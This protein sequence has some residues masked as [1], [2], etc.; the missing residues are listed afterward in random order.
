[1]TAS[2][3]CIKNSQL[4][5]MARKIKFEKEIKKHKHTK[6]KYGYEVIQI[7]DKIGDELHIDIWIEWG[8]LLGYVR[9]GGLI[10]HDYDIDFATNRMS[11]GQYRNFFK[12]LKS[13]GFK[14]TRQFRFKEDII[15][16]TYEYK[17]SLVDIDY[18]D[19]DENGIRYFEYDIG[20]NT[21]IEK[22]SG[23]YHYRCMDVMIY[24][25]IPFT[26]KRG[27]FSNGTSC[28]IPD[29]SED[30][31]EL[32]YGKNWRTPIPQFDW[33]S[34]NNFDVSIA[35]KDIIGWRKA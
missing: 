20:E 21:Q 6:E 13:K 34:L 9:E 26:I 33:K 24:H 22:K 11:D 12:I 7:I 1:M 25:A 17:G 23:R 5:K 2:F 18:C 8:T 29:N 30:H 4:V 27:V 35:N 10:G 32:F 19:T 14:L 28:N 15:S 16:E 3:K 31:I